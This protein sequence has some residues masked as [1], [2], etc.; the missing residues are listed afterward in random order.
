MMNK[1]FPIETFWFSHS[2]GTI[3]P[4]FAPGYN[5]RVVYENPNVSIVDTLRQTEGWQGHALRKIQK[6]LIALDDCEGL[7]FKAEYDFNATR[8]AAAAVFIAEHGTK[9][10]MCELNIT[11]NEIYK[12]S[13][14]PPPDDDNCPV[15]SNN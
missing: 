2:N 10:S 8:E 1:T 14:L 4:D 11:R 12:N 15:Y 7:T 9:P 3:N 5:N 13:D 6:N